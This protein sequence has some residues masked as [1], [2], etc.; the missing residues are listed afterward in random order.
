DAVFIVAQTTTSSRM[1]L[2]LEKVSGYVYLVSVLGVTGAR[3]GVSDSTLELVS[4]VK[5]KTDV[6]VLVG[7][8]VSE[9]AHARKLVSA[10]ADGVIVGSA[11]VKIIERNLGDKEKMIGEIGEFV[12]GMKEGLERSYH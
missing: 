11:I 4:K 9:P 1:S 12:R 2:I 10:G 8:G 3:S 6:P 5:G 7:F